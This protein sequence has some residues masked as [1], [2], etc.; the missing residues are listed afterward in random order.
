MKNKGFLCLV[1]AFLSPILILGQNVSIVGE[2]NEPNAL[3]RL[4]AYDDMLTCCQ[5]Q[6]AETQSDKDGKFVLKATVEEIT[7]VDIAVGIERV[8]FIICPNSS[9]DIRISV[10]KR[11]PGVSYYET[12]PPTMYINSINDGGFYQQYSEVD[13]MV[14]GFIYF[15]IDKIMYGNDLSLLEE[16][17]NQLYKRFGKIKFKYTNDLV[18]YRKATVESVVN[19]KKVLNEYFDNQEVLYSHPTYMMV[20]NDVFKSDFNDADFLSRNPQLA[21]LI[22]LNRIYEKFE[23]KKYDKKTALKALDDIKKSSKYQK[24]KDVATSFAKLVNDLTYDSEAPDFALMDK[25]GKT[26]KL[27]DYQNDMVLLQFV[28]RYSPL[29][30]HEFEEL[31]KLQKQWNDTIQVVTIATSETFA[32]NVQ[33]FD[34]QGYKWQI[35]NLGDNILL[36]EKYHVKMFPSYVILKKKG[37]VGMAPAPSPDHK[38]DIQVRRIYK[39]L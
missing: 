27:S 20:F 22:T 12:E 39:Y 4:L 37:R 9:Y 32:D 26:V 19:R 13:D 8:D 14:N 17:D 3:V 2:T 38:L 15:N 7:P 1:L 23:N 18:R 11:E 30:K 21:E 6:L 35:L 33:I 5:T 16:I 24:N 31:N 28:D 10:S 25:S 36:L 29:S 34:N